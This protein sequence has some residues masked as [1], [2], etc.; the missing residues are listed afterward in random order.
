MGWTLKNKPI[1]QYTPPEIDIDEH[2][3]FTE[4]ISIPVC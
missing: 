2:N 4:K 1:P 3:S